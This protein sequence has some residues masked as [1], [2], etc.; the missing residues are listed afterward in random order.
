MM[1]D[2][3]FGAL[4]S[5]ASP[6]NTHHVYGGFTGIASAAS[7]ASASWTVA[8]Q[9]GVGNSMVFCVSPNPFIYGTALNL[10]GATSG[11]SLTLA[12]IAASTNGFQGGVWSNN[13]GGGSVFDSA[14]TLTVLSGFG[15]L[16]DGTTLSA[17]TTVNSMKFTSTGSNDDIWQFDVSHGG[18]AVQSLWKTVHYG[19]WYKTD[20][21]CSTASVNFDDVN[22]HGAGLGTTDYVNITNTA[23]AGTCASTIEIQSGGGGGVVTTL[24]GNWYWKDL[25]YDGQSATATFANG[26][27]IIAA[28]NTFVAGQV[29]NFA[30]TSALPTNFATTTRYCVSSTNLSSAQFSVSATVT[31]A[32]AGTLVSA[33]SAGSGTQTVINGHQVAM[34][35]ATNI[36]GATCSSGTTTLTTAGLPTDN[37]VTTGISVAIENVTPSVWNGTFSGITVSGNNISYAQTCPGSSYTSG[38]A[39]VAQVGATMSGPAIANIPFALFSVGSGVQTIT[40]G[41]HVWHN[42]AK[43]QYSATTPGLLSVSTSLLP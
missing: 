20:I 37:N 35:N 33:G 5:V 4:S 15:P 30:T 12:N 16:N 34:Y 8:S 41:I 43:I 19:V 3:S 14:N 22:I 17:G 25:L 42:Y 27:A 40:S 32:C 1:G 28:T 11:T 18:T 26:S 9:K 29:V 36:T 2:S 39:I 6:Y 21:N 31:P 10:S 23:G 38:G 13:G 24:G 7:T